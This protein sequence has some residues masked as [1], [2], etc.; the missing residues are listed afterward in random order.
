M[1]L[2]IP[3]QGKA[4][5]K[6]WPVLK[7]RP[8]LD[9]TVRNFDGGWNVIDSDLNLD[10]RYAKVLDNMM[11]AAD[12]TLELRY[13]TKLFH[14]FE[15]LGFTNIVAS[16]YYNDFEIV[17]D[18]SGMVG[19]GD[20]QGNTYR[21]WDSVIASHLPGQPNGWSECQFASFAEFNGELIICNGIDKPLV[22]Q[23]N[24]YVSYLQDPGT[25]SN[26]NTPICRYVCAHNNYCIQAG[27]P[28][29]PSVLFIPSQGTSNTFLGDPAPNDAIEFDV[30]PWVAQGSYEIT[31]VG[32]FRNKLVV[33]FKECIVIMTLG[34]YTTDPDDPSVS[35]HTPTVDDVIN[36]YGSVG[37][38][39]IQSLGEDLLFMDLGGVPS[40][41]RAL[42]TDN[43]SPVRESQLIDPDIQ[44]KLRTLSTATL[45]DRCFA[46]HDKRSYTTMFFVPNSTN[47][48]T[49]VET[50]GYA[51]RN[52]RALKVRAWSRIRGWN[53]RCGNRTAEGRVVFCKGP[54]TFLFGSSLTTEQYEADLI[55]HAET[56][57]DGTVHTDGTGFT[58]VATLNAD[59]TARSVNASGIPIFFDWQLPWA[60]L[61]K[62]GLAKVS[63]FVK[64]ETTG[65]GAFDLEMFID[66]IM[67]S[68][69]Y[70]ESFVDG[71]YFT[72]GYGWT[73]G[74]DTFAPQLMM[75]MVGGSRLGF[76]G[77][78]FSDYFG[79]NRI[80][81]DER[82]FA[83]PSKFNIF[84]LRV[85][86]RTR[87][88]LRFI[89][90]TLFYQL[91]NIRR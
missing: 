26:A 9:V 11:R 64:I 70:G 43:I 88:P 15:D 17:V 3:S 34:V 7:E 28:L 76:G 29:R 47:E 75:E 53:W 55:G 73:P 41:Q 19:A 68:S 25:G 4:L 1:T 91:A 52:I 35:I 36:N 20:G 33:C 24:L 90:I 71:T 84:K 51:Y 42:L 87:G 16:W 80:S 30:G 31:G 37:H 45:Q 14:D 50:I 2:R 40:I 44:D 85:H 81:S 21:I 86:G 62:R 59:G 77:E 39:L 46:V 38:H 67:Y 18:E 63:R 69:P 66:N 49:T 65:V 13:G 89:S 74:M 82:L 61:K 23:S 6:R 79:G 56:Y 8:L 54:R 12:G 72:D 83:W 22:V 57:S 27:D 10:T 32:T 48:D 78:E 60:D 58:P 5:T